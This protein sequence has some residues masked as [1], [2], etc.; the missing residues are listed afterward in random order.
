MGVRKSSGVHSKFWFLFWKEEFCLSIYHLSIYLSIYLSVCRSVC[1]SVGLSVCLSIICLSVCLSIIS[2]SIYHLSVYH[3]SVCLSV[4]LS[5]VC[6]SVFWL[7]TGYSFS[8]AIVAGLLRRQMLN[9][10]PSFPHFIL[11]RPRCPL[12]TGDHGIIRLSHLLSSMHTTRPYHFNILLNRN[13]HF[14]FLEGR[15]QFQCNISCYL[16]F[17]G[18]DVCSGNDWWQIFKNLAV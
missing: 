4:H 16:I 6:L 13:C 10:S 17:L 12:P 7:S 14:Y 3:L 8:A 11:C 1:L 18:Y 15:E 9:S 5:S 2:L